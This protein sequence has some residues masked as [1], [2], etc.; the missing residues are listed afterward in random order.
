MRERDKNMSITDTV[1]DA[2]VRAVLKEHGIPVP[3]RGKVGAGH[4]AEYEKITAGGGGEPGGEPW[5]GPDGDA[6]VV[7]RGADP[8]EDSPSPAVAIAEFEAGQDE[9]RPVRPK[10]KRPGLA[11]RLR[12]S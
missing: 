10:R 9:A 12:G 5:D 2:D 6:M 1:S 7:T 11:D 8:Y 3:E 4:R